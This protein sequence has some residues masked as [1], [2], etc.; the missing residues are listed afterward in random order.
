M[1]LSPY[2]LLALV[3]LVVGTILK[4]VGY[5]PQIFDAVSATDACGL[6]GL[7]MTGIGLLDIAFREL[8]RQWD[9]L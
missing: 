3:A 1:L 9:Q 2:L 6:M 4:F 8:R 5:D 7:A